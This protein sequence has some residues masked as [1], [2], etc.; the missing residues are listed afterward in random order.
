MPIPRFRF[1]ANGEATLDAPELAL[2]E[3]HRYQLS[4]RIDAAHFDTAQLRAALEERLEGLAGGGGALEKRWLAND[5]TGE[6]LHVLAQLAPPAQPERREG[7]W[8][9]RKGTRRCSSRKRARPDG[10]STDSSGR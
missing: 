2:I 5:P 4:D 6:T 3:R 7:V 8:F 1:V 9:S 10:T